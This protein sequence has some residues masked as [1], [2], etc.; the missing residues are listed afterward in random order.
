MHLSLVS[1]RIGAFQAWRVSCSGR[2]SLLNECRQAIVLEWMR[3]SLNKSQRFLCVRV[4]AWYNFAFYDWLFRSMKTG[5]AHCPRAL[6]Y[7]S[8]SVLRPHTHALSGFSAT[9]HQHAN[10]HW[11]SCFELAVLSVSEMARCHFESELIYT[12]TLTPKFDQNVYPILIM[13]L[14]KFVSIILF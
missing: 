4:Q 1:S 5:L 8:S 3:L 12:K 2:L 6:N 7:L 14:F 10:G 9:L 11:L 13:Q